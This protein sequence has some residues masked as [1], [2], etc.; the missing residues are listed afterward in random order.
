MSEVG[1]EATRF[2]LTS[3]YNCTFC[4]FLCD[5]LDPVRLLNYD[6]HDLG[7]VY[8]SKLP[9]VTEWF[10]RAYE[11]DA[12]RGSPPKVRWTNPRWWPRWRLARLRE[13]CQSAL[14]E[15]FVKTRCASDCSNR[16]PAT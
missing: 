9:G 4:A 12:Q 13:L 6:L 8:E 11:R 7:I 5:D 14:D 3:K 15:F 2:L 10:W 16:H 1:K